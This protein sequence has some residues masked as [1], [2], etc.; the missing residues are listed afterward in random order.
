MQQLITFAQSD[1]IA[2]DIDNE[3]LT[4]IANRVI[5]QFVEDDASMGDW[6]DL[7]DKG[8]ELAKPDI[9]PRSSPW[10]GAANY[11]HTGLMSASIAFGDRAS[12]ELLKDRDLF[13]LPL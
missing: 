11:K 8:I 13:L 10:Q 7:V 3:V 6:K 5:E 2:E 9:H 1:N 12:A 4:K